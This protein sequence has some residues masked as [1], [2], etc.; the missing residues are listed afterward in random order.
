MPYQNRFVEEKLLTKFAFAPSPNR[1]DKHRWVEITL[2][3]VGTIAT[4]FSHTTEDIGDT[5]WKLIARQ[6]RVT[7]TFLNGMMTC[8]NSREAYYRQ[9]QTAPTPL[10]WQR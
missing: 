3:V 5:L 1:S 10:P 2:P 9:V 6:L 4:H 8:S 7:T